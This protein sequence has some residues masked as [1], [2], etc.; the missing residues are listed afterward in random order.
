MALRTWARILLAAFGVSALAGASQL[1]VAYGLGVVRLTRVFDVTTR[2]QWTAQLAWVAWFAMVAAVIGALAGARFLQ[3]ADGPADVAG[4]TGTSG[5]TD[6]ADPGLWTNLALAVV[7][8]LGASAVV[9]LTMQPARTAQVAAVSPTL[10]IGICATLGALVGVFAGYAALAHLVARWSLGVV[11]G[12]AW[13][14]AIVSVAPSLGAHDPLPA[15]R[16][17]VFDAG[18]LAPGTTQRFALFTMPAVA[19]L[20]GAALGWAARRRGF[21]AVVIGLAGLPGPALLMLAYLIAGPGEGG[22]RYQVVP[23]WAATAAVGTGVLGAVLAAMIRRNTENED[24]E[25]PTAPEKEPP[26]DPGAGDRPGGH[27]P[28]RRR[29]TGAPDPQTPAPAD[30]FSPSPGPPPAVPSFG[31]PSFGGPSFGSPSF[32][33]PSFGRPAGPAFLPRQIGS[34]PLGAGAVPGRPIAPPPPVGL[35]P[36]VRPTAPTGTSED[37]A[38]RRARADTDAPVRRKDEDV[39][40]WVSGLGGD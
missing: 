18:F 33:A 27:P 15:V 4:G 36:E 30:P 2:D 23:Y 32:G 3:R 16:L 22:Q 34:P 6:P 1:G 21:S 37:V 38:D 5:D 24:G 25:E 10:V 31:G 8:G 28:L 35:P 39:A 14:I 40:D 26:T 29:A 12:V 9:P 13:L 20:A 11:I 19:L 7:A 17:G